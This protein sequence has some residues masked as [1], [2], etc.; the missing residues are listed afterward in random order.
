M[1]R[2]LAGGPRRNRRAELSQKC[3]KTAH[4]RAVSRARALATA[5]RRLHRGPPELLVQGRARRAPR[6]GRAPAPRRADPHATVTTPSRSETGSRGGRERRS[7]RRRPGPLDLREQRLGHHAV[8]HALQRRARR[9]GGRRGGASGRLAAA[10]CRTAPSTIAT[11]ATSRGV[12][13]RHEPELRRRDHA[14]PAAAQ[15]LDQPLAAAGVEL[16]H[17]V[18]EQHQRRG[19]ADLGE[20]LALGQQ[21][22]RAGPGAAGRASRRRAGRG[23]RA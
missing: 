22:R 9:A 6:G 14:L 12:G 2:S 19:A 8:G 21:Q 20:L 11:R 15:H 1:C 3:C 7:G 4:F 10:V 17:R 5:R 23:P 16:G 18:V 13:A